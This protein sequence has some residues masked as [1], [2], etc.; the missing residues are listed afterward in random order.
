MLVL[1]LLQVV[2]FR[3][4][5][6]V[7]DGGVFVLYGVVGSE[8]SDGVCNVGFLKMAVL[9]SVGVLCIDRSR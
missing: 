5:V 4:F 7:S 6:H 8:W 2:G 1:L 3:P 9:K